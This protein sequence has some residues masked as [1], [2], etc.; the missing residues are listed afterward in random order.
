MDKGK[1]HSCMGACPKCGKH[2]VRIEY[3][4]LEARLIELA[5]KFELWGC[6]EHVDGKAFIRVG[7]ALPAPEAE[8]KADR[9]WKFF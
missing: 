5:R 1:K 9:H 7:D 3:R 2:L 4:G 8:T 6:L